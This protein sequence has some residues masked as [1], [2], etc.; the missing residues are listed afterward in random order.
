MNGKRRSQWKKL[1]EAPVSKSIDGALARTL[2][3]GFCT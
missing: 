3:T 1:K 2:R